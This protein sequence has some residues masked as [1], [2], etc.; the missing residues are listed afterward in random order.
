MD[1]LCYADQSMLVFKDR[2]NL[3]AVSII[4]QFEIAMLFYNKHIFDDRIEITSIGGLPVGISSEEYV[5]GNFSNARNRI[6]ADLFLRCKIVE[7]MGTGVRRIKYAYKEYE[8]D[9]EFKLYENS[10]QVILPRISIQDSHKKSEIKRQPLAAEGEKLLN[11]IKASEGIKR[12]E[13]EKFMNVGK[14]KATNLLNE[15]VNKKYLIK[16]GVGKNT[17]Y[18]IR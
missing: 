4:E 3:N 13:V 6:I 15:L 18:K 5:N 12:S 14:T 1:F 16:V 2:I 17:V 9:P 7:K 10:I 11:Y 8:E